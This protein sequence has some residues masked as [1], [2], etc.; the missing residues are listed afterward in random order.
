MIDESEVSDLFQEALGLVAE[1]GSNAPAEVVPVSLSPIIH[2]EDGSLLSAFN[3]IESD[4]I[5]CQ[6][7]LVGQPD[8]L[9]SLSPILVTEVDDW[10]RE[11]CN[12]VA[13]QL[14]NSLVT[15]G[16]HCQV[17]LPST[18]YYKEWLS[19]Q[20]EWRAFEVTTKGGSFLAAGQFE[21]N[22][23]MEGSIGVQDQALSAGSVVLY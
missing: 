2:A 9:Q 6:F 18:V 11:I 5:T 16:V 21:I 19:D 8:V 17:G 12:L 13:G 15:F 10:L 22:S 7:I 1:L 23:K 3:S 14:K 20:H 4:A